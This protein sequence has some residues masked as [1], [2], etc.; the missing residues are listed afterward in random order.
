MKKLGLPSPEPQ[1]FVM[2]Y[3]D[4]NNIE[5]MDSQGVPTSVADPS[6]IITSEVRTNVT[7]EGVS[8][9]NGDNSLYQA[10]KTQTRK[11]NENTQHTYYWIEEV[12]TPV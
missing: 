9:T 12:Q 8:D 4:I 6:T 5:Q 1:H 3:T 2:K 11:L 10:Y 7:Y